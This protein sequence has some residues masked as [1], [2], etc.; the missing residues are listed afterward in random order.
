M[1]PNQD[2]A[3]R[4]RRW[5]AVCL[6]LTALIISGSV[7]AQTGLPPG[8]RA[9]LVR[10]RDAQNLAPQLRKMLSGIPGET[11]V[12]IDTEENRILVQGS[13]QAQQLAT[14]F[15]QA[16]DQPARAAA[17]PQPKPEN[18]VRAYPTNG[19]DPIA[20]AAKLQKQFRAARVEPDVRTGQVIVLAPE[21][22]HRQV[23]AVFAGQEDPTAQQV[24]QPQRGAEH[25]LQY[26]SWRDFEQ[27]LQRLWGT[28]VSFTAT[29]DG[30]IATVMLATEN[31]PQPIMRIDRGTNTVVF[32]GD[33]GVAGV[34]RKLTQAIDKPL[35]RGE[36]SHLVSLRNADPTKVQRAVALAQ[37][38]TGIDDKGLT[39]AT[40]PLRRNVRTAMLQQ[41]GQPADNQP[42]PAAP[43]D[44]DPPAEGQPMG[45]APAGG[46]GLIGSVQ[47]EFLEGLDAIIIRGRPQDVARVREI[48]EEIERLS[49]ETQPVVVVYALKHVNGEA[50]VTLVQELYE[51]ILSP[52]QGPVSIRALVEPNSV[53]LIG[54]EESVAVV[55]ALID[56]LDQPTAPATQFE[57]FNLKHVSAAAAEAAVRGFFVNQPGGDDEVRPGLGTRV[58]IIADIRTNSLI[59]HASQRDLAEVRRF[60]ESMDAKDTTAS[61]QVRIFMLKNALA[62]EL[63]TV[64]QNAISG[65]GTGQTQPTQPGQPGQPATTPGATQLPSTALEFML[66]DEAGGRLLRSGIMADVQIT[67]DANTNALVVRAPANSMELLSALIERLD[68][69]PDAEAQIKVFTVVN[70]DATSLAATMQ[71]LFGQQVT[72]GQGTGGALGIALR[73]TQQLQGQ[74]AGGES[75]LIP[76][77]FAVDVRTNSVIVSGSETDLSIVETLLFR[78]DESGFN[79]SQL[80]VYRLKNNSSEF[81]ATALLDYVT[82]LQT[83]LNN[84][85]NLGLSTS[86]DQLA[87]QIIVVSEAQSNSVIVSASPRFMDEILKVI[88]EL[89]FRPPMVMVQVLIAEVTLSNNLELG[90]ELGF[91][92]AL[93]FDR[94]IAGTSST[95]GF[96]FNNG[97]NLPN[98]SD[99]AR[100][101]VATQGVADLGLGRTSRT[102][103]SGGLVLSAASDS[104]NV[105]VRALEAEGRLQIISRPQVMALNNEQAVVSVGQDISRITG[106]T[107]TNGV[108]TTNVVDVE[109][110][111][112]LR[113]QPRIND[114]GIVVMAVDA[115]K[116]DL[117]LDEDGTEIPN[118]DGKT[119]IAKPI[120]RTTAQT[121]ISAK[122]GQTVVLGGLITKDDEVISRGIPWLRDIPLVGRA[123]EFNSTVQRRTELLVILTPYIVQEDEDYEM[124]KS[125]ESQRMHWCLA[126]VVDLD[127]ERGLDGAGC[128]FCQNDVPV[129]Y[130]HH[131]PSGAAFVA[132][133]QSAHEH[134]HHHAAPPLA[135]PN[136]MPPVPLTPVQQIPERAAQG[137]E[138]SQLPPVNRAG[139]TPAEYV[140]GGARSTAQPTT[141]TAP[142][143]RTQTQDPTPQPQQSRFKPAWFPFR[144]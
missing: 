98:L 19:S 106:T 3:Q 24:A 67:A 97:V 103:G 27:Q 49:I 28:Q 96:N 117:G 4:P 83:T 33:A 102:V 87:T 36:Q 61:S 60:I 108:V 119:V 37:P 62:D 126:D 82:R 113:I 135:A 76:L 11:Q 73:Q 44:Q 38:V 81:V 66:I 105:L 42:A 89:D 46:A 142:I 51:E 99:F 12:L 59:V 1:R 75:S 77:T 84:S 5:R 93:L 138:L 144:R 29:Q 111:L 130:P 45:D 124:I 110:G 16:L 120:N 30:Q 127:G 74:T 21:G 58:R 57:I 122:S 41:D 85:V 52:R 70:G 63:A 90:T 54:R 107:V 109:T 114:D 34:W 64:L 133:E 55:T 71:Q 143:P 80:V 43:A 94:G 123:F 65:G 56:K 7:L 137:R 32:N 95:P 100:Q 128:L 132:T 26:V 115:T 136:G 10:N 39:T 47:I 68:Q 50:L 53:L 8:Y 31:G 17:T 121:T 91:Q 72:I 112:T 140:P 118:G 129:L 125:I 88:K 48:I 69:M 18:V 9:Y 116:S 134:E 6:L 25:L 22:T 101:T 13:A 20:V 2:L 35:R 23:A 131:D 78:L 15:I 86:L 92:N 141:Y 79:T 40:I 139:A 104:L 14:Q